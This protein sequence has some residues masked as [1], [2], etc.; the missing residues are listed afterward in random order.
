M[1]ARLTPDQKVGRSNRSGLMYFLPKLDDPS[2]N[3]LVALVLPAASLCRLFLCCP[4]V[5][6]S[7]GAVIPPSFS[8]PLALWPN[9]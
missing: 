9:G 2:N 8:L 6:S 3:Q 4:I 1:V 5:V 7:Y